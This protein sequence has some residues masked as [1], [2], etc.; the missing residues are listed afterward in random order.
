MSAKVTLSD[1]GGFMDLLKAFIA[2][3]I[4]LLAVT[5]IVNYAV[6]ASPYAAKVIQEDPL[7]AARDFAE[8]FVTVVNPSAHQSA[9]TKIVNI[10][11]ISPS[12]F[13]VLS[14]IVDAILFTIFGL[15]LLASL[16]LW[17]GVRTIWKGHRSILSL[18]TL[19][20]ASLSLIGSVLAL[21]GLILLLT[22]DVT[23]VVNQGMALTLSS[24]SIY[25]ALPFPWPMTMGTL[26]WI[27]GIGIVGILL[28][29]FLVRDG[30]ISL[31]LRL[32]QY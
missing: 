11:G 14:A 32:W 1:L 13:F 29:I 2:W 6:L 22:T 19:V 21:I 31:V 25:M 10:F 15:A 26:L 12:F 23:P 17:F 24:S 8:F 4:I 20:G 18:A 27:L 9:F 7:R 5:L 28:L 30:G 3:T 16:R